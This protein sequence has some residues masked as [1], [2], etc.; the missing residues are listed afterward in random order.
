[1]APSVECGYSDFGVDLSAEDF[2]AMLAAWRP[3]Q[4]AAE[5]EEAKA[6]EPDE[7]EVKSSPKRRKSL[8]RMTAAFL[9][10]SA[11]GRAS[12]V[13]HTLILRA[14]ERALMASPST[15][16]GTA[17][18][19]SAL[20]IDDNAYPSR[21]AGWFAGNA[22]ALLRRNRQVMNKNTSRPLERLE[23]TSAAAGEPK[24]RQIM[25]VNSDGS[26]TEGRKITWH[27]PAPGNRPAW[28][29]YQ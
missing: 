1:V 4:K 21:R 24:V 6:D 29:R 3:S 19:R 23:E 8:N 28:T 18:N 17:Q 7:E 9:C 10:L 22:I 15:D 27:P 5:P 13:I 20:G 14:R 26:R 2:E 25:I 16:V 12:F 11:L